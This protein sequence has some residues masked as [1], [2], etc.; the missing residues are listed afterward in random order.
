LKTTNSLLKNS[1]NESFILWR[2]H[3]W[4]DVFESLRRFG[5]LDAR[6]GYAAASL[7]MRIRL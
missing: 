1:K 2:A 6:V 3:C 7:G 5:S 4:D